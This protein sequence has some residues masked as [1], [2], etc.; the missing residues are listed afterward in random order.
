MIDTQAE[1][2]STGKQARALARSWDLLQRFAMSDDDWTD[3]AWK[4]LEHS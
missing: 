2:R 1:N 4:A 3:R